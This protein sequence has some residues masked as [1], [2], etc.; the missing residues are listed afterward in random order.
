MVK[1]RN[2]RAVKKA[3]R[4]QRKVVSERI[5]IRGP[6][7]NGIGQAT[8]HLARSLADPFVQ[9]ACIP[10]G[11]KGTSCFTFKQTGVL[12]TGATGSCY[13]LA[14]GLESNKFVYVDSG[15]NSAAPSLAGNWSVAT[16][17][18]T[19]ITTFQSYR[20][21]SA[22]IKIS[23]TG[24][25]VNDSGVIIVAQVPANQALSV[26][27]GN[28]LTNLANTMNNY[29]TYP[30]RN[31]AVISWRPNAEDVMSEWRV[32]SNTVTASTD[33]ND[34]PYLLVAVYGAAINGASSCQYEVIGNYE[35]QY[36][37]QSFIPGGISSQSSDSTTAEP[38]WYENSM[39]LLQNVPAIVPYITAP[40]QSMVGYGV[41][42]ASQAIVGG[43]GTAIGMA[44]SDQ[45][46]RG[47]VRIRNDL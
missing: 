44:L 40:M 31:G 5:T 22:G 29:K 30:L 36:K 23:Y 21:V 46:R 34:H 1:A 14:C 8:R 12:T 20:L 2:K 28:T 17:A 24:T 15:S 43:F 16:G 9:S 45:M 37:L 47:R 11:S 38:A 3:R 19:L 26:Y 25:T 18:G 41:G 13:S 4:P 33:N 6:R 32:S 42:V 35:G 27:S 7:G 10:D 39:R